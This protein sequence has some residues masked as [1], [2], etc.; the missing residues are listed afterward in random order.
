MGRSLLNVAGVSFFLVAAPLS[1]ANAAD[2][3]PLKAP[4]PAPALNWTGCNVNVGVG[5]GMYNIDQFGVG[6]LPTSTSTEGGRGWLGRFGA[7]CD[8][9]ISPRFV[10]GVFGDYDVMGLNANFSPGATG[11]VGKENESGAWYVGGR[12]GY[13]VTPTL[14]SYFDGGFTQTRFD[15]INYGSLVPPFGA[16]A[17]FTP[18]NTYQGWFLGSGVEYALNFDWLPVRGLFWRNEYRFS[19][20]NSATLPILTAAGGA[21]GVS[22]HMQPFVQTVTTS[23]VWRF[24]WTGAGPM[25][26]RY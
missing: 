4:P 14:L 2:L 12:I 20:Y 7:G 13:L 5:Y 26:P 18:G 15:Q 8:Y 3:L 10:I 6:A 16:A 25:G 22:E 19:E 21:T 17:F 24:N 11:V 1:L 9:Q 23:L